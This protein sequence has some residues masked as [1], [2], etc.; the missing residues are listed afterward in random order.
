MIETQ[1]VD[2]KYRFI[3]VVVICSIFF[4]HISAT[5]QGLNIW[6][7]A[8]RNLP[9]TSE[10]NPAVIS[11][12]HAKVSAGLKVFHLGFVPDASFSLRENHVN[13]SLPFY[14]P[15]QIGVGFDV[16]YFEG[17]IYSEL[18]G[19]LLLSREFFHRF[20]LGFK[21]GIE[22]RSFSR[23]NFNLVDPNDPVLMGSLASKS[24][25][26]GFG[27]YWNPG[28]FTFGVGIDHVNRANIGLMN[29][30]LLPREISAA[31]GYNIGI[32]TPTL[33]LYDDGMSKY[34]GISIAA[35]P[36]TS[37]QVRLSYKND[38][39]FKIEV[40]LNLSKNSNLTYGV[41]L[42]TKGTHTVSNGSHEISYCHIFAREP[43]IAVP[44]IS[45][46]TLELQILEETISRSLP[47][48]MTLETLANLDELAPEY[49]SPIR[50]FNQKII[51]TAGSL[52]Q[53]ETELDRKNR[54]RRLGTA[55]SKITLHNSDWK[56]MVRADDYTIE[57]A[58]LLKDFLLQNQIVTDSE[59][60][61]VEFSSQE[62]ADLDGFEPGCITKVHKELQL[63]AVN[64]IMQLVVLS[65]TRRTQGWQ[66][67]IQNSRGKVV[68]S[69]AA[70][71]ILPETLIWDWTD[72]NRK[73]VKP[74][75]YTFHLELKAKSGKSL[76]SDINQI[77]VTYI[78]RKVMLKFSSW[79]PGS[80][81]LI[82]RIHGTLNCE[83]KIDNNVIK[84]NNEKDREKKNESEN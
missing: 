79:G 83:E 15:Y 69:Y 64:L 23:D 75:R 12:Q 57:D 54:F 38:M 20:S 30:A 1:V 28:S 25:N 59:I 39:P 11:F 53:D 50:Q 10:I 67:Q 84:T 66:L 44:E 35:T 52:T 17:G 4:T 47:S 5:A 8:D 40:S 45:F 58:G 34:L 13:M 77:N 73:I 29:Q 80:R 26:L 81:Q 7:P 60:T 65:K 62:R 19:A 55:V 16:R 31:V 42:P 22:H 37:S 24:L 14:L 21:I 27:A 49:L 48:E 71:G 36:N 72:V 46:S 76:K 63:S 74:G 9:W 2:L 18:A 3:L 82:N 78:K 32:L 41:D 51:L 6:N 61:I 43:D 33:V 68:K 56:I 70:K